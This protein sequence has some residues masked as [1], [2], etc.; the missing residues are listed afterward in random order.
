MSIVSATITLVISSWLYLSPA[1]SITLACT[2]CLSVTNAPT[3]VLTLKNN[4]QTVSYTL[5]LNMNNTSTLTGWHLTITSIQY[6][7]GTHT[8]PKTASSVT[9]VTATC[10]SGQVCIANPQNTTT[11]P[12]TIPAD[13][14]A[15]TAVTFFNAQSATGLGTFDLAVTVHVTVPANAYKGNYTSTLIIT[16]V[17]GP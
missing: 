16:F 9:G 15:P 10:S 7:N 4:D 11:Y 1:T 8:L 2:D 14:P 13:N 5:T 17:S 3:A 6:T 12:I